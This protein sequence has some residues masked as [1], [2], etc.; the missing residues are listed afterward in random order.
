MRFLRPW[1][2]WIEKK[3]P[4]RKGEESAEK[5][6]EMYSAGQEVTRK[7]QPDEFCEQVLRNRQ[8]VEKSKCCR[9]AITGEQGAGKNTQLQK[10]A[11][12]VFDVGAGSRESSVKF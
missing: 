8:L 11:G 7:F 2:W 6:S 12:W 9:L 10:I 4:R 3:Q 5:G 1:D